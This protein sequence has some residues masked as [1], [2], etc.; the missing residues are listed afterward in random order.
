MKY[1]IIMVDFG[2]RGYEAIVH[3]ED[4]RSDTIAR[5]KEAI[6]DG[7]PIAHIKFVDGDE[8]QD[9]TDEFLHCAKWGDHMMAAE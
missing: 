2:R 1:W 3:P 4:S 7:Y 9:V 8:I 5:V 6:G